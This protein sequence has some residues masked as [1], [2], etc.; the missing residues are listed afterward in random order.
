[1]QNLWLLL[2]ISNEYLINCVPSRW[3]RTK[4]PKT[5]LNANAIFVMFNHYPPVF[6][7]LLFLCSKP[8]N[9]TFVSWP[10]YTKNQSP[11]W[12]HL[13][14]LSPIK[15]IFKKTT[16]PICLFSQKP[17]PT[18][19]KI[20]YKTN[21]PLQLL[22]ILPEWLNLFAP[23]SLKINVLKIHPKRTN[24]PQSPPPVR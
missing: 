6:L 24:T 13:S 4:K 2:N 1:M 11:I 3:T 17:F 10:I 21:Q 9:Q 5:H 8:R 23:S 12:N 15:Y 19:K 18:Q 16:P 22:V 14:K 7:C 20:K